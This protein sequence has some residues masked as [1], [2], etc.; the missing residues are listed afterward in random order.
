MPVEWESLNEK[1]DP[2]AYTLATVPALA[3]KR[4]DPWEE[5]WAV[6]QRLPNL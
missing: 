3:G 4:S 1:L 6:R 5:M 2:C